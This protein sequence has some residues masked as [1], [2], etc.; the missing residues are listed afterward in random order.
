MS[1]A[2]P[3][4]SRGTKEPTVKIHRQKHRGLRKPWN[5]GESGNPAGRPKG[6]RNK[7]SEEFVADLHA[8]WSANGKRVLQKVRTN[9]PDAYLKV[10]ASLVP[11]HIEA[12]ISG[13]THEDFV[14]EMTQAIAEYDAERASREEKLKL[15]VGATDEKPAVG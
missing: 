4:D 10:V 13:R 11:R 9:R 3:K 15:A 7:L 1:K 5:P 2:A 8:D 14:A 12:E 6:A